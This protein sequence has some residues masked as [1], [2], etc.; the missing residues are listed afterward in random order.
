[1]GRVCHRPSWEWHV[2]RLTFSTVIKAH[3]L[4]NENPQGF[5][6]INDLE[7]AEYITHLHLFASSMAPLEHI[8]TGVDNTAVYIWDR[9]GSVS[10]TTA[11]GPLLRETAWIMRQAKIHAS[12]YRIPGVETIEAEVASRVTHLPVHIY[13]PIVQH[14]IPTAHA[15]EAVPTSIR[16]DVEAT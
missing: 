15:L 1:M 9:W 5:L 2:W 8:T 4:T 16:S 12:N 3:I 13:S 6:T 11:I 10:T 14:F 7:L